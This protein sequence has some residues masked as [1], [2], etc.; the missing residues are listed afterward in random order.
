MPK[1]HLDIWLKQCKEILVSYGWNEDSVDMDNEAWL[2]YYTDGL[3]PQDAVHAE[4]L[5][6]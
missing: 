1:E 3:E 4:T 5:A 2:E 6:G